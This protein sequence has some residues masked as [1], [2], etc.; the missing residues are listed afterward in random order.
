M[1]TAKQIAAQELITKLGLTNVLTEGSM[2]QSQMTGGS[3]FLDEIDS[4]LYYYVEKYEIDWAFRIDE[5]TLST[6]EVLARKVVQYFSKYNS[7]AFKA[8]LDY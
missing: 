8:L 7:K 6:R 4:T 5:E 1:K 3:F 2:V